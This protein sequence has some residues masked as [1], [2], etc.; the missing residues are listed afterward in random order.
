MKPPFRL[1]IIGGGFSGSMTAAQ[2]LR[3]ARQAGLNVE[4]VLV[5]RRGTLGEGL[6]YGTREPAHLLNVPAGRMSAWPDR[7]GDFVQWASR[8]YL[9]VRPTDFMPR[10]WY[11]EYVRESLLNTAAEAGATTRLSVV[12]DE[13]RRVPGVPPPV[14]GEEP[15]LG[16]QV[17]TT[18]IVREIRDRQR[19]VRMVEDPGHAS[20]R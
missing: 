18:S 5:E 8:R 6:A 12:F 11:G 14:R 19:R 16:G 13:V 20:P 3:R 15:S 17:E 9:E 7:P 10:Q 2:T 1:A 4:V